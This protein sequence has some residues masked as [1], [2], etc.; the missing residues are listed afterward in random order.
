MANVTSL[1]SII[2]HKPANTPLIA[3]TGVVL[4]LTILTAGWYTPSG[5]FLGVFDLH[6]AW[7]FLARRYDFMRSSAHQRTLTRFRVVQHRVIALSGTDFRKFFFN[8]GKLAWR[9]AYL[10]LMSG[11]PE[12]TDIDMHEQVTDDAVRKRTVQLFS[13]SRLE[14]LRP[15]FLE[16]MQTQMD[17]WGSSGKF[18]VFEDVFSLIYQFTVHMTTCRELAHN[19]EDLRHLYEYYYTIESSSTPFSMM[20]PWIRSP[21][22]GRKR[23]ATE[24]LVGLLMKYIQLRRESKTMSTDA[25]DVC[26]NDGI[27]DQEI[28]EFVLETIFA[29]V[30][31][32]GVNACWILVYLGFNPE[33]KDKITT[34]IYTL[35]DAHAPVTGPGDTIE[36]RLA[37]VPTS[38]WDDSMPMLDLAIREVLRL[39]TAS[40]TLLRRNKL[41][42][43]KLGAE[44]IPKDAFLA[45]N[46][47]DIHFDPSVY[48]DP[49]SF[50][51]SR[52]SAERAEGKE[53]PNAFLGWGA[54]RHPCL[55][56]KVAK[57]EMKII[58][59]HVL[60]A[61]KY[62]IVDGN[63]TPLKQAPI[64]DRNNIH[65]AKPLGDP[66]YIKYERKT[67]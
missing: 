13:P 61:F 2:F 19:P 9:E 8:D 55:G 12:V 58:V 39:I 57:L 15:A 31:N 45:Y 47:S 64:H 60:G 59:A 42:D 35:L 56:L 6:R 30:I 5:S 65:K 26:I 3:F 4:L 11:M 37:S 52:F 33:W 22:L 24:K 10:V 46:L 66:C 14:C 25:F 16:H 49:M 17:R 40:I 36:S 50:D 41:R 27:S 38:A 28:I 20:F 43:L 23:Q 67:K 21:A 51:P 48:S 18:A 32:T 62:T 29:G 1:Q 34:E 44:P 54:G 63:G 7:K 53:V